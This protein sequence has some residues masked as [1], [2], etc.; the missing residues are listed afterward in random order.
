[1]VKHLVMWKLKPEA[2]AT[3]EIFAEN[4]RTVRGN[5]QKLREAVPEI[6]GL[7]IYESFSEG[8]YD[9]VVIMDFDSP[10]DMLTFQRSPAHHEKESYDFC[11]R[12]RESKAT[13]DYIV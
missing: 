9:F 5:F 10:E 6:H 13:V 12:V 1:M 11:L 8:T 3:P 2:K 7:E 4:M